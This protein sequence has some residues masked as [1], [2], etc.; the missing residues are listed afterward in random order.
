MDG[1]TAV[2]PNLATLSVWLVN[3]LTSPCSHSKILE[4]DETFKAI[5]EVLNAALADRPAKNA[6]SDRPNVG[7]LPS[8]VLMP[9]TA[10]EE[11]SLAILTLCRERPIGRDNLSLRKA[12]RFIAM[13]GEESYVGAGVVV[14]VSDEAAQ[15]FLAE[16]RTKAKDCPVRDQTKFVGVPAE[17]C[18][19]FFETSGQW[20]EAVMTAVQTES[21][22]GP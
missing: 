5:D 18:T 15:R 9:Y 12:S 20:D 7:T 17:A 13:R 3:S 14:F 22:T 6:A 8:D 4:H 1:L 11:P 10:D 19:R 2:T 21:S 16:L